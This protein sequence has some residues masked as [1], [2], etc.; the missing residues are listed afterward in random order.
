[1]DHSRPLSRR[2]REGEGPLRVRGRDKRGRR[3]RE[4]EGLERVRGRDKRQV[5]LS[6]CAP[7]PLPRKREKTGYE[8]F[9]RASERERGRRQ[10]TSP[11]SERER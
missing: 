3:E 5:T 1:M 2:K 6:G 11:L 7:P 10:V 4:G 9:E 8:P